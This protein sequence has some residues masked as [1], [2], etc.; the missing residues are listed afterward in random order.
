LDRLRYYDGQFY[1]QE[2]PDFHGEKLI[3]AGSSVLSEETK[4]PALDMCS[5]HLKK[6]FFSTD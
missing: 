1:N 3:K 4:L 2:Y 6:R 5:K